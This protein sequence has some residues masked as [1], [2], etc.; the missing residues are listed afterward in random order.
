MSH[1][2]SSSVRYMP[3]IDVNERDWL[4]L[5]RFPSADAEREAIRVLMEHGKLNFTAYRNEEWYVRTP[6]ALVLRQLGVPFD[7]LTENA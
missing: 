5:I 4:E 6:I 1:R 3:H 7:W 2:N